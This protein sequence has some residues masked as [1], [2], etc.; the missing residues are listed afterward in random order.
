ME[1]GELCVISSPCSIISDWLLSTWSE[2]TCSPFAADPGVNCDA[3]GGVDLVGTIVDVTGLLVVTDIVD[4][5]E[6]PDD[7]SRGLDATI[8]VTILLVMSLVDVSGIVGLIE[9]IWLH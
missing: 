7:V 1:F 8:E 6:D 4:T 3:T 5:V 9:F 2:T